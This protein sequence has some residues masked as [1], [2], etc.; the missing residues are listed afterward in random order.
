M[1]SLRLIVKSFRQTLDKNNTS[2]AAAFAGTWNLDKNENFDKF[3]QEVGVGVIKRKVAAGLKPKLTFSISANGFTLDN[4]KGKV[5]N[6]DG[7]SKKKTI[8]VQLLVQPFGNSKVIKWLVF[9]RSKRAARRSTL[10]GKLSG[11]SC[12]KFWKVMELLL[13]VLLTKH[14]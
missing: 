8:S 1:G 2:M 5:S 4:N 11:D 12:T 3:L 13:N 10:Q 7:E 6:V 14:N 9:L